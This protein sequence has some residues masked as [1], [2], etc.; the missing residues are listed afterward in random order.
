MT[1]FLNEVKGPDNKMHEGMKQYVIERGSEAAMRFSII[2][3]QLKHLLGETLTTL[4]AVIADERQLKAAKSLV[5]NQFHSK[6]D[7]IYEQCGCPEDEQDY[8][9]SALGE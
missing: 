5:K 6:I 3:Y 1:F 7:W 9:P 8:L 2:S 4:E